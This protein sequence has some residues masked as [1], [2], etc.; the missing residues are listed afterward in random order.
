MKRIA[1]LVAL[2]MALSCFTAFADSNFTTSADSNTEEF[3]MTE[4]IKLLSDFGFWDSN[5]NHNTPTRAEFAQLL[6]RVL[7]R[8]SA[9]PLQQMCDMGIMKSYGDGNTAADE[10]V[11]FEQVVASVVCMTGYETLAYDLGGYPSGYIA[12]ATKLKILNGIDLKNIQSIS[13]A[14]I[15][16]IVVNALDVDLVMEYTYGDYR[17]DHDSNILSVYHNIYRSKGVVTDNGISSLYVSFSSAGRGNAVINNTLYNAG[18]INITEYLGCMVDYYYKEKSG[19]APMLVSVRINEHNHKSIV[20]D[21]K[22]IIETS[23]T[24]IQ[25][26]EENVKRRTASISDAAYIYNGVA[27]PDCTEADMKP[28][29][30]YIELISSN[31]SSKYDVVKIWSYTDYVVEDFNL[32]T[33][34]LK[35]RYGR[36]TELDPDNGIVEVYD[37]ENNPRFVIDVNQDSVA[38]VAESKNGN[39]KKVLLSKQSIKGKVSRTFVSDDRSMVTIDDEDY[40]I[41]REYSENTHFSKYDIGLDFNGTFYLNAFGEIAGVDKAKSTDML[42]GFIIRSVE[43][44]PSDEPVIV[45]LFSE[46]GKMEKFECAKKIRIDGQRPASNSD[47]ISRLSQGR[48]VLYKL[49]EDGELSQVDTTDLG[50]ATGDE[51]GKTLRLDAEG[52]MYYRSSNGFDGRVFVSNSTVVLKVEPMNNITGD[53]DYYSVSRGS[54]FGDQTSY[55]IAAYSIDDNSFISDYVVRY[56][57]QGNGT[58]SNSARLLL[59]EKVYDKV[60]DNEVVTAVKGIRSGTYVDEVM[61]KNDILSTDGA[62]ITEISGGDVIRTEVAEGKIESWERVYDY[63]TGVFFKP[64]DYSYGDQIH[65][66]CGSVTRLRENIMEIARNAEPNDPSAELLKYKASGY[67]IMVYD[68]STRKPTVYSGKYTDIKSY[69]DYPNEYTKAIIFQEWGDPRDLVI[70]K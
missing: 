70:Y 15:A 49:N 51:A 5:L 65:I 20:I 54:D 14:D 68:T 2:V 66:A 10:P 8:N 41:S 46:T 45:K 37:T 6:D 67:R 4:D 34:E 48:L 33:F 7:N 57:D 17:I 18:S 62:S 27:Y 42:A 12:Q 58:V 22:D 52:N 43:G 11:T 40:A 30:G 24:Q 47:I 26:Y 61:R 69:E 50:S 28:D 60:V 21:A 23:H 25:Y 32:D 55:N 3:I 35:A 56:S 36:T 9:N 53:E 29:I 39:Y 44:S 59:V 16:A 31:G 1:V 63:D 19:E 38:S 64:A 13:T